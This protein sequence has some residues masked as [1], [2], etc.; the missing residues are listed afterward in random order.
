[1]HIT[2]AERTC[3]V[4][5]RVRDFPAVRPV[6][7]R[8]IRPSEIRLLYAGN[9]YVRV[10]VRGKCTQRAGTDAGYWSHV[11]GRP[12]DAG[13]LRDTSHAPPELRELAERFAPPDFTA[14]S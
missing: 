12:S 5:L 11:E 4:L 7:C 3:E 13:N 10:E 9:G 14:V 2:S 1:M 6:D 8:E